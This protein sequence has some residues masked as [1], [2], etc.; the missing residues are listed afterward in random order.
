M[1]LNIHISFELIKP[2]EIRFKNHI[3][4]SVKREKRLHHFSQH[5][6]VHIIVEEKFH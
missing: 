1:N 5:C 6:I 3:K 2:L 4:T